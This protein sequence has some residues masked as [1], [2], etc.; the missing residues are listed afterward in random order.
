M[1]GLGFRVWG[2]RPNSCNGGGSIIGTG[3]RASGAGQSMANRAVLETS[4]LE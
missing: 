3:F 1:P 2:L 4:D